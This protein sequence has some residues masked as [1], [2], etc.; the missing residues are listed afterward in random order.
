[1]DIK[2][3]IGEANF[4]LWQMVPLRLCAVITLWNL[5]RE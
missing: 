2:S 1:M 5:L 4:R 3:Q